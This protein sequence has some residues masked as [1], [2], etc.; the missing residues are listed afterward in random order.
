MD[1][2]IEQMLIDHNESKHG[3]S[4]RT[5]SLEE[6]GSGWNRGHVIYEWHYRVRDS[7]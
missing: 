4:W 7:Y 6:I 1:K 5:V 2:I 3:V